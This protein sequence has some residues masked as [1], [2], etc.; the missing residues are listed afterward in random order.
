VRAVD[1]KNYTNT[2]VP[3]A[4][5][6]RRRNARR[7][8]CSCP[9]PTNQCAIRIDKPRS[10]ESAGAHEIVPLPLIFAVAVEDLQRSLKSCEM[11]DYLLAAA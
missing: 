8:S 1:E 3:N 10:E 2:S 6:G 9:R 4:R 7:H 11:Q 5:L